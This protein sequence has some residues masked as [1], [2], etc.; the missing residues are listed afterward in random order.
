M[1][2]AALYHRASTVDQDKSLARD[3]LRA[4]AAARGCEIVLDVEETGSGARNDRPGLQRIMNAA[5]RRSNRA[6]SQHFPTP[7]HQSTRPLFPFPFQLP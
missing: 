1:I 2:R 6:A 5:R 7:F 4:A 3:E